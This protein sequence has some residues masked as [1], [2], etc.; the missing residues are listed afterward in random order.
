M[1]IRLDI[2]DAGFHAIS[3]RLADKGEES[4]LVGGCVRDQLLGIDPKDIDIATTALPEKVQEVFETAGFKVLPTGLQHGTVTVMHDGVP[5]EVTTLRTDVETDGRHAKVAYIRDWGHDAERRDFTIN[6]MSV[7]A[8]GILHDYFG[9]Y[10]D[11]M[12]GRVRFVGDA[13]RRITEDYLRILRFFRFRARFGSTVDDAVFDAIVKH[14]GGLHDIS[15]ERIWSEVSKIICHQD[16]YGQIL[17][18][19]ELGVLP[20]IGFNADP[21]YLS[22]LRQMRR[23]TERPGMILGAMVSGEMQAAELAAEW[24]LSSDEAADAVLAART[25]ADFT[26]DEHYWLCKAV[27]LADPLKL[28]PSLRMNRLRQ[29]ADAIEAG[30]PVFPLMG[31]DLIAVGMKPGPA[32]GRTLSDLR[33]EWKDSRFTIDKDS[34]LSLVQSGDPRP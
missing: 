1:T 6:A 31:R 29:A 25:L 20:N 15:V 12:E 26:E 30:V 3:T 21:R 27:D 11:L 28:V 22:G 16:G 4:R 2:N 13:A 23:H 34:L 8:D 9:G 14:A 32:L 5:Y 17:L 18:M 19:D 24:K 7:G 33:Q 10:D